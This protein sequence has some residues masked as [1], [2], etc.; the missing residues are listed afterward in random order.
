L[1]P[2]QESDYAVNLLPPQSPVVV[3]APFDQTEW[4]SAT[5]SRPG[6]KVDDVVNLRPLQAPTTP[7]NEDEEWPNAADRR[8]PLLV[9]AVQRA[10][11]LLVTFQP[12]PGLT[13]TRIPAKQAAKVDV[14]VN[15]LPLQAA[16]IIFPFSLDDWST[17]AQRRPLPKVDLI[18]RSMPLFTPN[19][20]RPFINPII[21]NLNAPKRP[22]AIVDVVENLVPVQNPPP[23]GG[24]VFEWL[25][26]ARRRGRR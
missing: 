11:S 21:A 2:S 16:P 4:P 13:E 5:R 19:P 25:T 23:P 22:G 24:N 1:R 6:A 20:A 12:F 9:D 26:R 14:V 10:L 7:F 18:E 3:A 15:L 8:R 17:V